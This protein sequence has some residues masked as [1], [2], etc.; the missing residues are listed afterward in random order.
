MPMIGVMT[1]LLVLF[2]VL[3]PLTAGEDFTW[4]PSAHAVR[5]HPRRVGDHVLWID[6]RGTYY[7]DGRVMTADALVHALSAWYH[8]AARDEILYVKADRQVHY[9]AVAR[10]LRLASVGGVRVVGAIVEPAPPQGPL[11][12]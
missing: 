6:Q 1:V 11:Q 12:Y 8:P 7:L 9:G 2:A 10:A 5:S 4:A 3:L